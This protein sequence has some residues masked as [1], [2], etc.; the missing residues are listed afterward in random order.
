MLNSCIKNSKLKINAP[1]SLVKPIFRT[2][3]YTKMPDESKSQIAAIQILSIVT[4]WGKINLLKITDEASVN[5]RFSYDKNGG[6]TRLGNKGGLF[7]VTEFLVKN[8]TCVTES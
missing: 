5:I 8:K 4:R 3:Y 6:R 7:E 2:S 1:I